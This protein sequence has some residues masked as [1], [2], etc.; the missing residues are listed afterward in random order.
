MI[1]SIYP[2]YDTTLYERS[3]SM[4]TGLD[5]ILELSHDATV[6]QSIYNSRILMKFD[7]SD[8]ESSVNSGKISQ[9]AKYYLSLKTVDASEIP[10]E[11]T[12]HAHPVSASWSNGTG[13]YFN[14]PQ[15]TDGASWL[16]RSSKNLGLLWDTDPVI[17]NYEWNLQSESWVEAYSSFG[18]NTTATV[19]YGYTSVSGGGTWWED[20]NIICTQSFSYATTDV[21]MDVTQIVKKWITGSGRFYNDGM[22]IKF[23][24]QLERQ[25][26]SISSIKFFSVDSNTI[27]V[28]KLYV[29][30]DDSVFSTG[31]LSPSTLDNININVKLNKY[32]SEG[33]KAKIRVDSNKRY[34]E[35][36][37]TTESYYTK[38]YYLPTSS[39]YEIRDAHTD[40]VII[41]F[42]VIGTKMSCDENGNYFNLW[43]NSFQPER[44]YRV[45]VKT[46]T[47][48][49]D[50]IRI[51]DNNYYFKV[52]R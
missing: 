51:F 20:D 39:F 12:I 10:Q 46:E 7:V 44:F 3:A 31:S 37:Y 24:N 29:V 15:T 48:G 17:D 43:M 2:Q 19:H 33:E 21:Y 34:P 38:K 30:W 49:G 13:K 50:T 18:I 28:P 9:S 22:I 42:D 40:E 23:S 8:V 14:K 6:T 16:Y 26:D 45:V 41:P 32:Y 36:A 1:Y 4:N 27:Y 25:L 11:Y 52:T 47:D 35:K 5:A